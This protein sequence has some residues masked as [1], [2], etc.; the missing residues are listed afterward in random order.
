M[1]ATECS[2]SSH[3][4]KTPYL[5]CQTLTINGLHKVWSLHPSAT[6]P[7]SLFKY[8]EDRLMQPWLWLLLLIPS[9]L[10]CHFLHLRRPSLTQ[11]YSYFLLPIKLIETYYQNLDQKSTKTIPQPNPQLIKIEANQKMLP[12]HSILKSKEEVVLGAT[13]APQICT[14]NLRSQI[15]LSTHLEEQ[16][17]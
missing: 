11:T 6:N 16:T 7:I 3:N 17:K 15:L 14:S 1:N 13:S 4:Q 8:L 10:P 12:P 2:I 9:L 5:I